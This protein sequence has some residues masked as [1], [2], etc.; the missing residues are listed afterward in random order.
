LGKERLEAVNRRY[1]RNSDVRLRELER[2]AIQT[3][4]H[5]D[6][7]AL[8]HEQRRTK[9]PREHMDLPFYEIVLPKMGPVL[10]GPQSNS[11]RIM[12]P[13]PGHDP[14]PVV[15]NRVEYKV[16]GAYFYY[17]ELGWVP[18]RPEHV[19][20]V[21]RGPF[22]QKREG[23]PS[24]DPTHRWQNSMDLERPDWR[25]RDQSASQSAFTRFMK[26]LDPAVKAWIDDHPNEMALGYRVYANNQIWRLQDEYDEL[27]KK[28]AELNT[29]VAQEVLTELRHA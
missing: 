29:A 4:D 2:R 23:P 26:A 7:L 8:Y 21:L 14:V 28:M 16:S 24:Y 19:E 15:V 6:A 27:A 11:I 20:N 18:V 17:L 22:G 12:S 25:R 13:G 5:N 9:G 3:G 10:L 1:R